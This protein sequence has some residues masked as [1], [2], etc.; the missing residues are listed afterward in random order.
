[1]CRTRK[2]TVLERSGYHS[3]TMRIENLTFVTMGEIAWQFTPVTE[4]AGTAPIGI[5]WDAY[6]GVEEI[7]RFP[8]DQWHRNFA[9]ILHGATVQQ[10]PSLQVAM[11]PTDTPGLFKVFADARPYTVAS[12]EYMVDVLYPPQGL[13]GATIKL[14]RS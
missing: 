3:K 9:V 11:H 10:P 2:I 6:P 1:M 12:G 5:A 14:I 4:Y 13:G 7:A 8:R